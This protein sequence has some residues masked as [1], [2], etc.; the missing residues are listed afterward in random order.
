MFFKAQDFNLVCQF[1]ACRTEED[2]IKM[3]YATIGFIGI[4]YAKEKFTIAKTNFITWWCNI[5]PEN[6]EKI[7]IYIKKF[8][9]R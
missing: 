7:L 6:Q 5:D 9:N 4:S 2:F 1:I 3:Y 8:Y